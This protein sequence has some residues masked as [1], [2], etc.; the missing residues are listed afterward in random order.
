LQISAGWGKS[1]GDE[2]AG[3]PHAM[4]ELRGDRRREQLV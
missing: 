1:L 2:P 3:L 4:R